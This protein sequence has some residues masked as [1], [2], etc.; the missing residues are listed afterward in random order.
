MKKT[1]VTT[2]ALL[3]LQGCIVPP[4]VNN[5]TMD[6]GKTAQE[7]RLFLQGDHRHLLGRYA[8]LMYDKG[9]RMDASMIN[10]PGSR[11]VILKVKEYQING[12][13]FSLHPISLNGI[14]PISC[15]SNKKPGY[16]I[17]F[18]ECKYSKKDI[19][20]SV[21]KNQNQG[22]NGLIVDESPNN[23]L[24]EAW[25]CSK[26]YYP[27]YKQAENVFGRMSVRKRYQREC[28]E[29]AYF[30]NKV[31]TPTLMS[32]G[33]IENEFTYRMSAFGNKHYRFSVDKDNKEF[34]KFLSK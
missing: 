5:I 34:L 10:I 30:P 17:R 21:I 13:D 15:K 6:N 8:N 3:L 29:P 26:K 31:H 25:E 19:R 32:D 9:L 23:T 24:S 22:L 33:I 14:K 20:N 12:L 11:Y 27:Q 16:A 28:I 4:K 18:L 7:Y 2:V 1:F